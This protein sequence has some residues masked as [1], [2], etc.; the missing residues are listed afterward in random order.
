MVVVLEEVTAWGMD[1]AWVMEEAWDLASAALPRPGPMWESVEEGFRGA[2]PM[3]DMAGRLSDMR[4]VA[5]PFPT[6]LLPMD[7]GLTGLRGPDGDLMGV[8]LP[9]GKRSVS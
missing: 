8:L 3:E 7:G 1:V 4:Q 9:R 2:G 6:L 5:V